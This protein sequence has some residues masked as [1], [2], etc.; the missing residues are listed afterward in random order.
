M[1]HVCATQ[2]LIKVVLWFKYQFSSQSLCYVG[3]GLTYCTLVWV[4]KQNEC[5]PLIALSPPHCLA[6]KDPFSQLLV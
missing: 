3:L 5:S 2:G 4:H 6:H 1:S